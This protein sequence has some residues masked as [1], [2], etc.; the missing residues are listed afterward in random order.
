MK[1]TCCNR[2]EFYFKLHLI[3]FLTKKVKLEKRAMK[4]PSL[5]RLG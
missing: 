2:K 4:R 5:K 3:V 1:T